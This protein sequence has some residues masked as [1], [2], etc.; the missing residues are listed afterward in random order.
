[1]REEPGVTWIKRENKKR[2]FMPSWV[3]E[4]IEILSVKN[5]FICFRVAGIN[6]NNNKNIVYYNGDDVRASLH[7][8]NKITAQV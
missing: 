1:M 2:Y 5:I 7:T 6:H 8:E 4:D 3:G